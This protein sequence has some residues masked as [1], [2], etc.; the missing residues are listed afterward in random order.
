MINQPIDFCSQLD[1]ALKPL[2]GSNTTYSAW[3][4]PIRVWP[5]LAHDQLTVALPTGH[6]SPDA[7]FTLTLSDALGR[8]VRTQSLTQA[9]QSVDGIGQLRPGH[10]LWRIAQD[11][12]LVG[13]GRFLTF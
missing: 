11:G 10:Y 1:I 6:F 8:V 13:Q 7:S 12:K 4:E 5:T 9:T 3:E 2:G